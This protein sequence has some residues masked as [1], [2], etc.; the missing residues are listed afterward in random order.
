MPVWVKSF[1]RTIGIFFSLLVTVGVAAYVTIIVLV[2][3]E[4][5]VVPNV[6]GKELEEAVTFLS[7]SKLSVRIIGK[8]FST[9]VPA[10]IVVS[11][12]P[13]PEIKV[14]ANRS[15]ELVISAGVEAVPVPSVVGRKLREAKMSLSQLGIQIANVS[16]VH[17]ETTQDEV[18]AQE[19]PGGR[20]MSREDRIN[21]LLSAGSVKEQLM[22]PDLSEKTITEAAEWFRNTTLNIAMI[23][24][25]LSSK[26]EGTVI[27]QVPPPGSMVEENSRIELVISSG[28]EQ[29]IQMS[30][31]QRWILTSVRLPLGLEKKRV[32][33]VIVDEEGRRTQDY[34]MRSPGE[35]VRIS[36]EVV[37]KGEIRIYVDGQLVKL[38]RVE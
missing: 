23:K 20:E 11:Q 35:S 12:S 26:E 18:I 28:K 16:Y 3:R 29:S 22:M 13:P 33:V 10:N 5:V 38:K 4:N 15:V 7:Q 36:S 6:V 8:K 9:E 1:L 37:G 27:S 19:P 14:R 30:S 24:E 34:G 32:S 17:S 31:R 21:L 2:P 25:E